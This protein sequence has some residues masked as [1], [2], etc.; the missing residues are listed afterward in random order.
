[1]IVTLCE[2]VNNT[3]ASMYTAI[4]GASFSLLP[5]IETGLFRGWTS[6]MPQAKTRRVDDSSKRHEGIRRWFLGCEDRF[7]GDGGVTA[8]L[9]FFD[10]LPWKLPLLSL[11]NKVCGSL[12][13]PRIMMLRP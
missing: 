7:R 11:D 2:H 9:S 3:T 4:F 6:T 8:V 10:V 1:M 13:K 5:L 12:D